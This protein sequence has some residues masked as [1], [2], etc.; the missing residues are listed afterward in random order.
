[1][2]LNYR[3]DSELAN[4]FS[5]VPPTCSSGPIALEVSTCVSQLALLRLKW[6]QMR[7]LPLQEQLCQFSH[8]QQTIHLTEQSKSKAHRLAISLNDMQMPIEAIVA[9]L[10]YLWSK[11]TQN[12]IPSEY[13]HL[14]TLQN[15]SP[16]HAYSISFMACFLAHYGYSIEKVAHFWPEILPNSLDSIKSQIEF[17]MFTRCF[18]KAQ[19]LGKVWIQSSTDRPKKQRTSRLESA[20]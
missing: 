18:R 17:R 16:S 3:E 12:K 5:P 13:R 1:M 15:E 7:L 14:L 6:H 8:H 9:K 19:E 4:N 2:A 10:A 11:S 20:A